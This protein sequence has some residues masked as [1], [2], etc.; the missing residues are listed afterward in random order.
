MLK[1]ELGASRVAFDADLTGTQLVLRS[2]RPGDRFQPLGMAGRKRVSDLLIDLKWPRLLRDEILL[3]TR[4]DEIL[5]VVGLRTSHR[6]RVRTATREI[7]LMELSRT[8]C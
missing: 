2:P 1:A 7:A 8:L 4:D 5:W 6:Y 3:L